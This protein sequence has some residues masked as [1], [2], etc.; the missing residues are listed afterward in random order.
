MFLFSLLGPSSSS[1]GF[2]FGLSHPRQLAFIDTTSRHTIIASHRITLSL[3]GIYQLYYFGHFLLSLCLSG[4]LPPPAS[5][6]T[7]QLCYHRY[8]FA[9]VFFFSG[10][11]NEFFFFASCCMYVTCTTTILFERSHHTIRLTIYQTIFYA[12]ITITT[13]SSSIT[14]SLPFHTYSFIPYI[15]IPN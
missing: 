2:G 7:N 4:S 15:T 6:T 5:S 11:T 8:S 12:T 3:S 1:L 13:F 10:L 9:F 14:L